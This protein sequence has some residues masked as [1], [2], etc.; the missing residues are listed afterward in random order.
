MT[1]WTWKQIV[2][3]KTPQTNE[4]FIQYMR[5][6]DRLLCVLTVAGALLM[7]LGLCGERMALPMHDFMACFYVGAGTGLMG[8]AAGMRIYHR[9]LYKNEEKIKKARRELS[10]ERL[11]A[12]NRAA[13]RMATIVLILV[14]YLIAFIGGLFN[15]MLTVMLCVVLGIFLLAYV[16]CYWI[17]SKKM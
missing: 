1:V 2:F 7:V 8:A 3:G 6:K 4:E 5:K 9:R 13:F 17:C 15:P 10:D 11:Q 16:I 14:L 12:V